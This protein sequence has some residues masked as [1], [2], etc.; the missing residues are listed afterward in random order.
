LFVKLSTAAKVRLW[1][2]TVN[3]LWVGQI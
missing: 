3:I 1:E 2:D